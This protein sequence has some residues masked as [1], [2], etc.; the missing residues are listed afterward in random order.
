MG[1]EALVSFDEESTLIPARRVSVRWSQ[2]RAKLAAARAKA[3]E[4][5]RHALKSADN[6]FFKS[7]YADLAEVSDACMAAL[8][9]SDIAVFQAP[10]TADDGS[11]GVTTS[12]VHSSGEWVE[13]D[14]T[15][16]P[17]DPGPQ[18]MGS[19]ITYLRR[20]SLA[21]LA[22][23]ATDDDDGEAAERGAVKKSP[24]L[25]SSAPV[26]SPPPGDSGLPSGVRGGAETAKDEKILESAI[27]SAKTLKDLRLLWDQLKA[28]AGVTAKGNL[29]RNDRLVKLYDK[30]KAEL[31]AEEHKKAME[32][33]SFFK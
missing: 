10:Y 7:K 33:P 20:Y 24:T 19:V 8:A 18:A 2:S 9:A 21:A 14:L 3:Q 31:E 22:G 32:M 27:N 13:C 29:P 1:G 28:F 11:V 26:E 16:R 30:K 23:V 5:I 6:P 17:K 4:G 12:L 15:A 25:P